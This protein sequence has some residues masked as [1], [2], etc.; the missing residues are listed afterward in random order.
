MEE[1]QAEDAEQ[2]VTESE[3]YFRAYTQEE[4][5][6]L[7]RHIDI[8]ITLGGDGTVLWTA[9]LF[10]EGPCPPVISFSMGSMGFLTPFHADDYKQVVTAVVEKG[11]FLS[12]RSRVEGIIYRASKEGGENGGEEPKTISLGKHSVLNEIVVDRGPA[13]TLGNLMAYCNGQILTRVQA[14]GIIIGTPTGSTAYSLSAG[15]SIVHP[16]VSNTLSLLQ[17]NVLPTYVWCPLLKSTDNI[18]C[19]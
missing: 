18:L 10:E 16:A 3:Q 15:G 14:D 7:H 2:W 4:R 12:I 5:K 13:S 11:C 19:F 6:Y 1:L 17:Y 9:Q 8:V